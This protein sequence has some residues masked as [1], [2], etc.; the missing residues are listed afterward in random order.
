[1]SKNFEQ[2]KA[3]KVN[4]LFGHMKLKSTQTT[5]N[6]FIS[7]V[8]MR[9]LNIF[10]RFNKTKHFFSGDHVYEP[11]TPVKRVIT[12]VEWLNWTSKEKCV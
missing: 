10:C 3:T 12:P 9:H 5:F 1:M 8:Y 7:H 2:S 4:V 11:Q 6:K